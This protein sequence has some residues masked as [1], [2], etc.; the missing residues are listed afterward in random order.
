MLSLAESKGILT[1]LNLGS[2]LYIFP[3]NV[4]RRT[5]KISQFEGRKLQLWFILY[6]IIAVHV[7]YQC[8]NMVIL[9]TADAGQIQLNHLPNQVFGVGVPLLL[10]PVLFN[11]LAFSRDLV[12]KIFNELLP[13]NYIIAKKRTWRDMSKQEIMSV[14]SPTLE[15]GQAIAYII[16]VMVD[17]EMYHLLINTRV[18]S[19]IRGFVPLLVFSSLF[20]GYAL[21]FWLLN[22]G[23]FVLFN[24]LVMS[25]VEHE[26]HD[27]LL[28]LK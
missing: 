11:T 3:F 20:E 2:R 8:T 21:A 22:A 6:A 26:L 19:K 17:S 7:L 4:D 5:G 16:A 14:G 25:K 13:P 24:C 10:H 23:F 12:E 1:Y 27:G 18:L 28:A 15:I 9:L